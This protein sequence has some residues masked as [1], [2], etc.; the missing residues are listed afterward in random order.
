MDV[1]VECMVKREIT[2]KQKMLK[3]LWIALVVISGM[4][5]LVFLIFLPIFLVTLV[6]ATYFKNRMD[7]IYEYTYLNGEI[8]FTRMTTNR[9]KKLFACTMER[10]DQVCPAKEFRAPGQ[11]FAKVRDFASGVKNDKVYVMVAN[12][13]K[14][15][16]KIYFE[17]DF[18]MLDAM[19]RNSPRIVKKN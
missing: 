7:A 6:L 11:G 3:N 8:T 9:R 14:G 5:S 15:K 19:W 13:E 1:Y 17:P 18:E 12:T 4:A 10:V 2:A 16:V